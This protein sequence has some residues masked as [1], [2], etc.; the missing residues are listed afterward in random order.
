MALY[1]APLCPVV[2]TPLSALTN[3]PGRGH[4]GTWDGQ[5]IG[6]NCIPFHSTITQSH[7]TNNRRLSSFKTL[8]FC[9]S[10][11]CVCVCVH[12]NFLKLV[13]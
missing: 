1:K 7:K 10:R 13:H 11:M 2:H 3:P 9:S 5:L 4:R 12:F 6:N 8:M